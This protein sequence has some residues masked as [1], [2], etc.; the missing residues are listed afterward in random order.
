MNN[1]RVYEILLDIK[2][3]TPIL[4]QE[5]G[6]IIHYARWWNHKNKTSKSKNAF[7]YGGNL[8][9][10]RYSISYKYLKDDCRWFIKNITG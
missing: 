8:L 3:I 5:I 6:N 1:S 9:K 7:T 2:M 4:Y 10:T